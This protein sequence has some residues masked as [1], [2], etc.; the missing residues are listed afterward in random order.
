MSIKTATKIAIYGVA[1][2]IIMNLSGQYLYDWLKN[3]LGM[4]SESALTFNR[5]YWCVRTIVLYGSILVFLITL[6]SK[7]KD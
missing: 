7:Q 3:E 4:S 2:G 1:V 5:A 6:N